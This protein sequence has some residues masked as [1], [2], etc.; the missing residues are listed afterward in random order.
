LDNT[1]NRG[2]AWG[3]DLPRIAHADTAPV[4][5][6]LFLDREPDEAKIRQSLEMAQ[7]M[8]AR[9]VKQLFPWDQI[10]PTTKGD[11]WVE[12]YNHSTWEH[13][14]L[15]V[16]LCQRHE[17]DLVVRLDRPPDWA[18]QKALD[19]PALQAAL[20]ENPDRDITGPPDNLEDY[21]DF[22]YAVVSRYQ[23]RVN[24]VQ[25]WN[26][27]NLANEWNWAPIDPQRFVEL[28]SIG[29]TRAKEANPDV[30]VLFPSLAPNDGLDPRHMS[31]LEFLQQVYEAG[32]GDYF[33][34]MS[35]QLYGLGQPPTE[36]ALLGI[37]RE[38]LRLITRTDVSRVVLLREL[39]EQY[40][41]EDKAVWV[42]EL[43]WNATPPDWTG[44][45][46]P[47]GPSVDEET[48]GQYIVEALERSLREWPW[49]G[50]HNLWFLHWDGAPPQ[51]QDPTPFF[52]LVDYGFTPLAAYDDVRNW[53]STQPPLGVGYHKLA[54]P[55]R[56]QASFYGTR[57]DLVLP[58]GT[59]TQALDVEIDGALT[60]LHFWREEGYETRYVAAKG[61]REGEH[62]VLIEG[63]PGLLQGCYVIREQP[64]PWL[65][66]LLTALLCLALI[67]VLILLMS[68]L[69][70]ILIDLW[71]RGWS[72]LEPF[73]SL[74]EQWQTR[75]ILGGIILT[76]GLFYLLDYLP[77][78]FAVLIAVCLFAIGVLLALL[79]LD[80]ALTVVVATIPLYT[81]PPSIAGRRFSLFELSILI[82]L[83]AGGLRWLREGN[84]RDL[85]SRLR[86]KQLLPALVFLLVSGGSLLWSTDRTF[87]TDEGVSLLRISLREF[88]VTVI[89]PFLLYPLLVIALPLGSAG[90]P[91]GSRSR[92]KQLQAQRQRRNR[93][94]WMVDAL[95]LSG[96]LV[97]L[98][99]IVQVFTP[100]IYKQIADGVARATS[101][102]GI[103][104]ANAL[105][106]FLGRVL[107]V[108]I[109]GG[110]FLPMSR[111]KWAYA[112]A[113][114][115]LG[116]AFFL[117]Y[118]R[119]GYIA[120][121]LVVLLY[122]LIHN[123]FLLAAEIV[124]G[125]GAIVMAWLTG[126]M[127][128]LMAT[129]TFSNRIVMWKNTWTLLQERPWLGLGLDAFYHYYHR[130]YPALE[131]AYWT[132]HNAILEFWT[133]L[134]LLGVAA[135]AW[136]YG[137]F[138]LRAS[139]IYQRSEEYSNRI[140]I[141]GLLGSVAYGLAH[142]FLD[143]TF[144]A[145]DWAATFWLAYGLVSVLQ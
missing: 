16:D 137:A 34:V 14:D 142:G 56:I 115:V 9:W 108:A 96:T 122:G 58:T 64:L 41:D 17:L 29:Y 101:I 114:P 143:G 131:E 93:I 24:Y 125:I 88:R 109:A 124:A 38:K 136:L 57:L 121:A 21:G 33:D 90:A 106:L 39:M 105:A 28:L 18:R 62:S 68:R 72:I 36:R 52:A 104:S 63:P 86:L 78:L 4:G 65:F 83:V 53:L 46:S 81:Q 92:T 13:Y 47:W 15:I 73:Y 26:E 129:D 12:G 37:D 118:S 43:G 127:D 25:L 23:G 27:P 79:R 71:D 120:L 98:G 80:L 2:V 77:K 113:L 48:K 119:G 123:R 112:I 76:L 145:P 117:T 51:R 103:F 49:M 84:L 61:L 69:P 107:A 5:V 111:R 95:V 7:Q 134:G 40:G 85:L 130:R 87:L 99:G 54:G 6:N 42:G 59:D 141:L 8:G 133:R 126:A 74:P 70:A 135:A 20:L 44:H 89:E 139:R 10:E 102:Y 116:A 75:T 32:G 138:F 3:A 91:V 82:C 55:E 110:L 132:P 22:V 50:V 1:L 35:A 94:W 31:D 60:H 45:P 11:Y 19:Q 66:P 128:R 144:F 140:L 100:G 30:I 67:V 97:A